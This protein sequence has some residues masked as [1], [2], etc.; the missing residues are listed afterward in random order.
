L[1]AGINRQ[2]YVCRIAIAAVTSLSLFCCFG[3]ERFI[4][5]DRKLA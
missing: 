3:F 1:S 4:P 5:E 2:S